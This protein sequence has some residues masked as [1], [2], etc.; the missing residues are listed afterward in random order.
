MHVATDEV[1][2]LTA[3]RSA[4]QAAGGWLLREAGGGE[5]FDGFGRELPDLAIARR[6]KA[7]FDPTGKR[8]LVLGAGGAARA[9]AVALSTAGATV[10]VAARRPEQAAEVAAL[11]A[12]IATAPWGDAARA[13]LV[14]NATPLGMHVNTAVRW[15]NYARRDWADYLAVRMTGTGKPS[16]DE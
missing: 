8:A 12:G 10:T 15:V 5:G 13:D 9:L 4:A 1:D 16:Q 6:L 7:A 3:A 11:A 2:A 14:V